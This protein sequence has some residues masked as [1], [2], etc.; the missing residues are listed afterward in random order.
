VVRF[1][2]TAPRRSG[3]IAAPAFEKER[4]MP[5]RLARVIAAGA[6]LLAACGAPSVTP[7]SSPASPATPTIVPFVTGVAVTATPSPVPLTPTPGVTWFGSGCDA[8][9]IV[10]ALAPTIE[11]AQS[12]LSHNYLLG[13]Y[14]LN[15]WI[16]DPGLEPL[17]QVSEIEAG[18]ALARRHAAVV[19]AQLNRADDCV[20]AVFDQIVVTVVDRDFN[21]WFSGSIAPQEL[22]TGGAMTDLEIDR[23]IEAFAP[24]FT[25]SAVTASTG[26]AAAPAEACSW[27]QAASAMAERLGEGRVNTALYFTIDDSGSNVWAQ[28]AGPPDVDVFVPQLIEIGL[29]LACLYPAPDTFWVVYTDAFGATQLVVA[30]PG[31][32]IRQGD[33]QL[34]LDQLQVVYPQPAE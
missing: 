25:R 27:D 20:G 8:N 5:K 2:L 32:V 31:E 24:G 22:P 15:A 34:M 30:E 29:E 9:Q 10:A 14:H 4:R 11:Y 33:T 19:S 1:G 23:A 16:V 7:A 21:S 6:L 18:V 17:A 12:S 13:V 3:I 26:R 28:W